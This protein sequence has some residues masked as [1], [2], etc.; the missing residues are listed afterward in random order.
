MT[1]IPLPRV[2]RS[3]GRNVQR[4]ASRNCFS[5]IWSKPGE[6]SI[7]NWALDTPGLA[8]AAQ[9]NTFT[10]ASTRCFFCTGM[11]VL[12]VVVLV[13]V[14]ALPIFVHRKPWEDFLHWYL[15]FFA[16][17]KAPAFAHFVPTI[18]GAALETDEALRS[19]RDKQSPRA[20]PMCF[21]TS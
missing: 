9:S 1:R 4:R 19:V 8:A 7:E 17:R 11:V 21:F 5:L 18:C 15:T 6:N 14:V 2:W 3:Q 13:V 10:Y 20:T 16:V 12:V